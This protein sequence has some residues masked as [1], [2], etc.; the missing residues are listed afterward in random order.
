M[1]SNVFEKL[2]DRPSF[3]P[4]SADRL[5]PS[6]RALPWQDIY[7]NA[8][9]SIEQLRAL[10]EHRAVSL[11]EWKSSW[12]RVLQ[13][14]EV[15]SH[16]PD[17]IRALKATLVPY[18]PLLVRAQKELEEI[19]HHRDRGILGEMQIDAFALT[20][21]KLE[22]SVQELEAHSGP[23]HE[24]DGYLRRLNKRLE[25]EKAILSESQ[26]KQADAPGMERIASHIIA[27]RRAQSQ[28][29]VTA[30]RLLHATQKE[31]YLVRQ[32]LEERLHLSSRAAAPILF[33]MAE[34]T[35]SPSIGSWFTQKKEGFFRFLVGKPSLPSLESLVDKYHRLAVQE[36]EFLAVKAGKK[37]AD[38]AVIVQPWWSSYS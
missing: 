23:L 25:E 19:R 38:P 24:I 16:H 31:A 14:Q 30:T 27:P 13:A 20:L 8:Q 7:R 34:G 1:I 11:P 21:E 5:P 22:L 33:T 36:D 35:Y 28:E 26:R 9:V 15:V 12:N 32:M 3:R 6:S 4:R 10:S 37:R 29:Q 2:N 17:W 18:H